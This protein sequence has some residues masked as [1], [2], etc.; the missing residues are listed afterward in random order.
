MP[1]NASIETPD[2]LTKDNGAGHIL[3][4]CSALWRLLR[5]SAKGHGRAFLT[6]YLMSIGGI[7]ASLCAPYFLARL[8]DEALP[9]HDLA[10]FRTYAAA[11]VLGLL[12]FFAFSCVKTWFLGTLTEGIFLSLRTRIVDTVLRKPMGFFLDHTAADIITRVSNDT[13]HLSLLMFDYA[14]ASLNGLTTIL[15]FTSLMIAWEW[16]LGLYIALTLPCYVL[17]LSCFQKPLTRA[18][19]A[20]RAKL[21]EQNDTLLDILSG[22]KEIRFYQKHVEATRR[23]RA[24]ATPFTMANTRSVLIGEWAYNTME[25]FARGIAVLPFLLGGYWIC[26]GES[27]L[28][29]GVL[30]AYNLYLTYIAYSLEVINVGMSKLAQTSPLVQR[31]Q[32][33]L[34]FPEEKIESGASCQEWI[35]TTCIEYRDVSYGFGPD[36]PLHRGFSLTIEPGEKLALMGPSGAGKTTLIELLTRRC[37][38]HRGDILFGGVPIQ[39]FSLPRYLLFFAYVSQTPYIFNTSVRENINAGWYDVPMDIIVDTAKRVRI[40]EDIML[41]PHGYDSVIGKNSVELSGG[42]RQR[43]A[44]ARA[45]VRDPEILLLDEFTSALDSAAEA[46]ILDD[47]FLHFKKQ[48]VICVTHSLAVARRF[49]RVVTLEKP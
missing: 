35:S 9:A 13:E 21:S 49:D 27:F 39:E 43:L 47:L 14:Y 23:Y 44:L 42:Q 16:R 26:H 19:K 37:T 45:L 28:S 22:S 40:H 36:K 24:S 20:A 11:T 8:L 17:I 48:T 34:D 1:L 38:P 18:A 31:I 15:F 41:L 10:L 32:E 12:A 2:S 46:A 7:S 29:T 5:P 6:A 3:S 4:V 33:L 30:I 25:T